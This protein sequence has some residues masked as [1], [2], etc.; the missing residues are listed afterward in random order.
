MDLRR[1]VLLLAGMVVA[2]AVGLGTGLIGGITESEEAP[3]R[4]ATST[5]PA[6]GLAWV[7]ESELPAET[8]EALRLIDAGGP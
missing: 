4:T 6:S 1:L 7:E 5:D 3:E 8:R 2:L